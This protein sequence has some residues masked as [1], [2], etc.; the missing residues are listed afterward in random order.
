MDIKNPMG[1]VKIDDFVVNAGQ[2]YVSSETVISGWDHAIPS[3]AS[4]Y[5]YYHAWFEAYV[6]EEKKKIDFGSTGQIY[7]A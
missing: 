4:G 2:N 5:P 1:K 6:R 7:N 3:D